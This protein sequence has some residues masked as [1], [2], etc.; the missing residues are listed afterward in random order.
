MEQFLADYGYF[1][2]LI[3]AFLE[4]ETLLILGGI[5]AHEGYLR[6][7]LVIALAALGGF[8]GDQVSFFLGHWRGRPFLNAHPKLA[9]RTERAFKLLDRYGNLFIVVM[10]FIYGIRTASAVVCG[11]AGISPGRFILFNSI[12]VVIWAVVVASG[13]YFLGEALTTVLG[14]IKRYQEYIIVC[15]VAAALLGVAVHRWRRTRPSQ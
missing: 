8:V 14:D 4:G 5:A 6:L 3:G 15:V 9:K 11:V 13:G 12:G 2:V 1:A 10:R 7:P